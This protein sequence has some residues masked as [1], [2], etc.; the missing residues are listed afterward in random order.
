MYKQF[1]GLKENP[2]KLAPDPAYLFV[3]SGHEEALAHLRYGLLEG[4]GFI[5]ITGKR[6]VGKTLI[7]AAFIE[8]L[9][10]KIK[11]AYFSNSV[12][13]SEQLLNKIH[14]K[15]EIIS[16]E[17]NAKSPLDAFYSFLMAQRRDR[18]RVVLIIDEAQKLEKDAFEQIRLLSNLETNRDKLLQI[19]LVGQPELT[20]MLN[21]Y[22][23]RQMG[24]R[25]SVSFQINPLSYPETKEYILYR[26][27]IASQ[28]TQ[29]EFDQSAFRYIFRYSNGIPRLINIACDK[30]LSTAYTYNRKRITGD[31]A[32]VA[33]RELIGGVDRDRWINFFSKNQSRLILAG[34]SISLV[35]AV[36]AYLKDGGSTSVYNFKELKKVTT[37]NRE[38]Q[39]PLKSTA[40]SS[41]SKIISKVVK[42]S[43]DSRKS[44]TATVLKLSQPQKTARQTYLTSKMTHSVQ[45]GAFLIKKNAEMITNKLR[46]KGYDARIVIFNDSKKRIWHT[47][48]IGDYPSREIAREYSDAFTAKEKIESAVVPVD[49]L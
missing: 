48:R 46:K 34:C 20:D 14:R 22:E 24:Q 27:N 30:V 19:V 49:N 36:A 15:F 17:Y 26:L 2:F 13:S 32:K 40:Q 3:S 10:E 33:I 42:K 41:K 5:S 4:E 43:A 38:P 47:V 37:F 1:F 29:I 31:V 44:E 7:C 35:I 16:D 18:K 8:G 39:K 45:V 25:I 21:S 6:G 23:L 11:V 28:E 9:S 12:L